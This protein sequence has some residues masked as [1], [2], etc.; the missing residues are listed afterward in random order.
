MLPTDHD[1]STQ[2]LL[3]SSS[4][5]PDLLDPQLS[6]EFQMQSRPITPENDLPDGE[7]LF[8]LSKSLWE[9]RGF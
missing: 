2:I 3:Q 9:N 1:F 4:A 5:Q 7:Q 6:H 8:S